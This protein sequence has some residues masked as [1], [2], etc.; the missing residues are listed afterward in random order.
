MDKNIEIVGKQLRDNTEKKTWREFANYL[1][2]K[3]TMFNFRRG[4]ECAAMQ[5]DKFIQRADW[6]AG[7]AEIYNS[8][9]KFESQLAKQ[10]V[11]C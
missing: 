5:L 3:V 8:L 10:Y 4:N 9:N 6:R 2:T 11:N 1:L 7:N